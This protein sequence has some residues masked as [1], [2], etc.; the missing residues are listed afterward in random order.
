MVN[1][2][3]VILLTS[4][5]GDLHDGFLWYNPTFNSKEECIEWTNNNPGPII[6]T[7]NSEFDDWII[8]NALCIREDKLKDLNMKPYIEGQTV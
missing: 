7:L 8:K 4:G 6:Q 3:L 1:W 5:V 2:Y